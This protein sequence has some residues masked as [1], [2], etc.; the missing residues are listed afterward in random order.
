LTAIGGK[1][2]QK[3]RQSRG[4][5]GT[6]AARHH[7]RPTLVSLFTS[8]PNTAARIPET[9][10]PPLLPVAFSTCLG[11]ASRFREDPEDV[12]RVGA[13]TFVY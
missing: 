7:S 5:I 6:L 9:T 2:T 8:T 13:V 4:T 1:E 11:R 3:D 12:C 10:S